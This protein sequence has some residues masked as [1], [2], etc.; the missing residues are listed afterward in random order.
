MPVTAEETRAT[1]AT[2]T[3]TM[4]GKTPPQKRS[5]APAR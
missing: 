1:T 4:P 2:A 5:P 3:M